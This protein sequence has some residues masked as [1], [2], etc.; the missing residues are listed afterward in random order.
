MGRE[1]TRPGG[2]VTKRGPVNRGGP[3]DKNVVF[4][5]SASPKSKIVTSGVSAMPQPICRSS[6]GKR[7]RS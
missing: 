5:I 7:K 1:V 3:Y 4:P 6:R 2:G